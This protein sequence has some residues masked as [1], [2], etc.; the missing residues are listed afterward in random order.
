MRSMLYCDNFLN[1]TVILRLSPRTVA[2][3]KCTEA[4]VRRCFAKKVFS[5]ISFLIKLQASGLTQVFSCEFCE[6]FKN[7]Y[8]IDHLWWLLLNTLDNNLLIVSNKESWK[9]MRTVDL[10]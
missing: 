10:A 7:T 2:C 1:F 8:F 3:W 5:K 6:N 9:A 4:V